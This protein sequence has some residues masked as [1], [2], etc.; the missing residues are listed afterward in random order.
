MPTP[1]DPSRPRPPAEATTLDATVRELVARASALGLRDDDIAAY[2]EGRLGSI[3][4]ARVRETLAQDPPL[5]RTLD[6][7]AADARRLR[8]TPTPAA[9]SGLVAAALQAAANTDASAPP[10]TEAPIG[11]ASPEELAALHYD[12]AETAHRSRR[13]GRR[14]LRT[15]AAW[16]GP[17]VGIAAALGL[18]VVL[19]PTTAPMAPSSPPLPGAEDGPIAVGRTASN[20]ADPEQPLII[21]DAS[22]LNATEQGFVFDSES[23]AS[24]MR[25]AS[26]L[27]TA[28]APSPM[29]FDRAAISSAQA[30]T[31]SVARVVVNAN[32]AA[33]LALEGRLAF[34]LTTHRPDR[35]APALDRMVY[36]DPRRG[37]D[38]QVVSAADAAQQSDAPED[39]TQQRR[40]AQLS[41]LIVDA[42]GTGPNS[43]APTANPGLLATRRPLPSRFELRRQ[44]AERGW[45]EDERAA[46]DLDESGETAR[47]LASGGSAVYLLK[48]APDAD[49]I[50]A[51]RSALDRPSWANVELIELDAP[52]RWPT[53]P[54]PSDA[55]W[56]TAPPETWR[57]PATIPLL[58]RPA[59]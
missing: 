38:W 58:V 51:A 42:P 5:A 9:P 8:T 23:I 31:P 16:A 56:W 41:L 18:A 6:A 4:T 50:E 7:M 24:R 36:A 54:T 32:R 45:V 34:R 2:A 39:M 49:S 12:I 46:A 13:P 57:T 55:L 22:D 47:H 40:L 52:I 33:E 3:D 11:A 26:P 20:L 27:E 1:N 30:T 59:R 25:A 15:T 37:S 28:A 10:A 21:A 19:W 53:P 14:L 35:T 17:V 44:P 48:A 43:K 29:A